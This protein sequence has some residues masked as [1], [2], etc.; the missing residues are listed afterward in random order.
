MTHTFLMEIGLEEMPAHVVTPSRQ[1]LVKRTQEFL[2]QN[3]LS[4]GKVSSFSTPRRL[5]VMVE[6]LAAKQ[7]DVKKEVR[8]PAKKI[9]QDADGNW[10]K[11]A[12][13]FVRGQKMTTDDIIFKEQKGEEYVFLDKFIP[14]EPAKEVLTGMKDVITAMTFSTNMHWGD[15]DFEYI[16]PIHWIVALLDQVIVPFQVLDIK[17]GRKTQGHR[18]L[19][20]AIEL[21]QASDYLTVLEGQFVIADP[22]KRQAMIE[23]QIQ[24]LVKANKWTVELDPDLLEEVVNL[25]E[26]PTAFSGTF[27]AKYLNMP[28]EVLITSMKDHQRYFY[29]RD[30][31]GKLLPNFISV[32]NGNAEHL[33]NVI[34]GNEKVLAARLEDAEFFYTEDQKQTIADYVARLKSVSF[35]DKIGTMYEKMQRVQ[36]IAQALGEKVGLTADELTDLQ[37]AS[38]IYKFDL[39]TGM[40]GE[41]PEL[42]GVMGEKYALLQG[43]RPAVAQAIREH[44]LPI[45]ADGVLP[46]SKV[47]AVLALADKFDSISSFFAVGMI[48][49]GSND[50][51]ALRRQAFGIVRILHDRQWHL[52]VTNFEQQMAQ[53]LEKHQVTFNLD[54]G[55]N[56]QPI[57]QFMDDR[58]RQWFGNHQVNYDI[59]DAVLGGHNNDL[60]AMFDAAQVLGEQRQDTNFKESIEALTRVLRL[61][62]KAN[63]GDQETLSVDPALFE[64][65]AEKNLYEAVKKVQE[66]TP[67]HSVAENFVALRDLRPLIEAYFEATMVMVDDEKIRKNRLTQLAILARLIFTVANLNELIVK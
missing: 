11:A 19:G 47:G 57:K 15:H 25:V 12:Q 42:Q 48:P 29:V 38:E 10:T 24:K 36:L 18:F 44:Y 40:V 53:L 63:F 14:G 66:A 35:H 4:Y 6:E 8:G 60:M 62:D 64:N 33:D 31:A 55:K 56:I 26:Y 16:R 22:A 34:S 58:M 61:A 52:S 51:Y 3:R 32:R 1:Q 65:D 43:E 2:Q 23:A 9:A 39:V 50:P 7:T 59:V 21:H 27:A 46:E 49:N 13:G 54:Y 28:D 67:K 17:S 41:F 37:R 45:S 20:K 5:T 30:Q